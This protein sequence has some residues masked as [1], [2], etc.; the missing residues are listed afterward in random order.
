VH[1]QSGCGRGGGIP[2]Q[3]AAN[4]CSHATK[5]KPEAKISHKPTLDSLDATWTAQASGQLV[6]PE[7]PSNT[8]A[9]IV[10]EPKHE[11]DTPRITV[12]DKAPSPDQIVVSHIIAPVDSTATDKDMC[13]ASNSCCK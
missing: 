9:C 7:K 6:T 10:V 3:N 12:H 5:T 8:R 1:N 4:T 2:N 11:K 13:E